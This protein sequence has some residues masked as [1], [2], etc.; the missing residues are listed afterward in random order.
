MTNLSTILIIIYQESK[1]F[2]CIGNREADL[3]FIGSYFWIFL[4]I[5]FK[6]INLTRKQKIY[7]IN[8]PKIK[9][10]QERYLHSKISS[11]PKSNNVLIDSWISPIWLIITILIYRTKSSSTATCTARRTAPKT[12]VM[13]VARKWRVVSVNTTR[14]GI[15]VS[16][17]LW[18]E[19]VRIKKFSRN[20]ATTSIVVVHGLKFP[21]SVSLNIAHLLVKGTN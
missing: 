10:R 20:S 18:L 7:T 3:S 13:V 9:E 4:K 2:S 6:A 11:K 16:L 19:Q 8:T 17:G 1:Q 5:F 21:T 15:H 12:K 14:V